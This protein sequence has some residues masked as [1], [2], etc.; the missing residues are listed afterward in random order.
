MVDYK[1][2]IKGDS[3]SVKVEIVNSKSLNFSFLKNEEI[4][5]TKRLKG[6][7]KKDECF[8]TRRVFY[9]VPLFPILFGWGN[10]Q[11]RIYH[12]DEE[13]IIEIAGNHG[14]GSVLLFMSADKYNDIWKF[15]QIEN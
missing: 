6:K 15:K 13:L 4:I 3:I 14:G 5:G 10:F 7:F 9:V 8:Y 12:T 2:S 1:R 11:K